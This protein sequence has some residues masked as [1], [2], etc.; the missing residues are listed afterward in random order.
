MLIWVFLYVISQCLGIIL[1]HVYPI[2][3]V[4]VHVQGLSISQ[5]L[6]NRNAD[7]SNLDYF[8]YFWHFDLFGTLIYLHFCT[9]FLKLKTNFYLKHFEL[10]KVIFIWNLF[11]I[12]N[13]TD[14]ETTCWHAHKTL[15]LCISIHA[16]IHLCILRKHRW[17]VN[18]A[19]CV[20]QSILH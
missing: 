2:E 5:P 8:I 10:C 4:N 3:V 9:Y 14:T 15:W 7:A 17:V 13:V 11:G 19:T 1:D 6:W 12:F 20:N 16:Y 18:K